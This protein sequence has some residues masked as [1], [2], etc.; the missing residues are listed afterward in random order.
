[1]TYLCITCRITIPVCIFVWYGFIVDLEVPS[2]DMRREFRQRWAQNL[3]RLFYACVV[4]PHLRRIE[5]TLLGSRKQEYGLETRRMSVK[6]PT[7]VQPF[8]LS[9]YMRTLGEMV[10]ASNGKEDPVVIIMSAFIL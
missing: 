6:I 7:E 5:S 4:R 8:T 2:E 9:R 10:A 1:M 3:A